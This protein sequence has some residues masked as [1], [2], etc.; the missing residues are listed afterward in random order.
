MDVLS[1]LK[2]LLPTLVLA[3]EY[4]LEIQKRVRSYPSKD[5]ATPLSQSLTDADLS[6]QNLFEIEL[7]ASHPELGFEPEE[8]DK[9]LNLKYFPENAQYTVTLDPVNGTSFYREGLPIFD[10]IATI[11][12]HGVIVGSVTYIPS[13]AIFY[14]AAKGEGAFTTTCARVLRGEDL[15]PYNLP[16]QPNDLVLTY[17]SPEIDEK[18]AGKFNFINLMD[19]EKDQKSWDIALFS[20]L[21]GR[22]CG[23]LKSQ[24][25]LIDWGAIAF[26]VEEAGGIVTDFGGQPIPNYWDFPLHRI[27]NIFCCTNRQLHAKILEIIS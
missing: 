27:P 3:G 17:R 22:I 1:T 18:L 8:A 6:I 14:L 12:N 24:A 15:L 23:Y 20:V 5:G 9:S 11:T 2:S 19:F 26:I 13:F 21:T 10:I 16:E 4:A 25:Q 7:L